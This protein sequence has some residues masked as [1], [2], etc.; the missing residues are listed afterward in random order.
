MSRGNMTRSGDR[1]ARQQA[2]AACWFAAARRVRSVLVIAG[3]LSLQSAVL[4]A[5]PP[6]S[7]GFVGAQTRQAP[8]PAPAPTPPPMHAAPP[9]QTPPQTPAQTR[10][11]TPPL[12]GPQPR[13]YVPFQ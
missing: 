1:Y 6:A 11:P 2:A 7:H 8:H 13:P 4:F 3:L 5:L 9:P 12:A 10:T